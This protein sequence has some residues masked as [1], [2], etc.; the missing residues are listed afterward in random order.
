MIDRSRSVDVVLFFPDE[1]DMNQVPTIVRAPTR[2]GMVTVIFAC[3]DDI[4]CS[5]CSWFVIFRHSTPKVEPAYRN[6]PDLLNH[7]GRAGNTYVPALAAQRIER[8]TT[9]VS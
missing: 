4:S 6:T 1:S 8:A 2:S 5:R 9:S 7:H 3:Y